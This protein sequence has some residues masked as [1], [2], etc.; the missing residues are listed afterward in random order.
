MNTPGSIAKAM[1]VPD[2][3]SIPHF[4]KEPLDLVESSLAQREPEQSHSMV[5][6]VQT[7]MV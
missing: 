4:G 7:K 2:I 1:K 5:V 6:L 3:R